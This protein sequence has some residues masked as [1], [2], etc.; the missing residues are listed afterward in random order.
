VA[1]NTPVDELLFEMEMSLCECFPTMTPLTLRKERSVDVF[2]LIV[3]YNRYA[4]KKKKAEKTSKGKKIIR[5]PA[6]DNWF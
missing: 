4:R 5:R 3:K 6:S 2:R 1:D